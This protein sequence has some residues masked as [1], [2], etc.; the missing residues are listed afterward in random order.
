MLKI[1]ILGLGVR[2][3]NAYN[4]V[5]RINILLFIR[6]P[7]LPPLVFLKIM[8]RISYHSIISGSIIAS[9]SQGINSI[10]TA[11]CCKKQYFQ[12]NFLL[13][14]LFTIVTVTAIKRHKKTATRCRYNTQNF[15]LKIYRK[16]ESA[17]A[18]GVGVVLSISQLLFL[19]LRLR[20]FRSLFARKE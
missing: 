9:L 8:I 1:S 19:C 3:A 11:K 2:G 14:N 5:F 17:I 4:F 6:E 16:Y 10:S 20:S 15:F 18:G 13:H 7:R 12:N